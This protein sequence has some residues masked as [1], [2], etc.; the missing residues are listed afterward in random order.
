MKQKVEGR[1]NEKEHGN[2]NH[3]EGNGK[4]IKTDMDSLSYAIGMNIGQS[5]KQQGLENID[6]NLMKAAMGDVMKGSTT[7]FTQEQA[8]PVIMG[9]MKKMSEKK[10]AG[11]KLEGAKFCQENA[12]KEG[13]TV[14]P[15][16]L[17][18]SIMKKGE[19]EIPKATD[20]VNVHYHG[21]LMNGKVFDS[22]VDRG[23]PATFGVTQV[24]AGWVEALQLMPV[25]SKWKLVIPS[26]LAYGD[27]GAGENIPPFSTLIFEVELLGIEKAAEPAK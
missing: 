7:L 21:T 19:G 24:I 13:V 6:L 1:G 16:G 20:K 5:L 14:L 2:E 8:M 23:T 12:K 26:D 9:S 25:G 17:Q 27:R 11:V 22:S 3:A 4:G 10:F 15:S 18:Y